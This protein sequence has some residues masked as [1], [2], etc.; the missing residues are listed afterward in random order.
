MLIHSLLLPKVFQTKNQVENTIKVNPNFDQIHF[1]YLEFLDPTS[2]R[3]DLVRHLWDTQFGS[4]KGDKQK[5][6]F[7]FNILAELI[8][9][10][11]STEN[12]TRLC[13]ITEKLVRRKWDFIFKCR[14]N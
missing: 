3:L 2:D 12:L 10:S 8:R 11:P 5:I 4:K 7:W 14:Y 9:N 6:L 1:S 13:K